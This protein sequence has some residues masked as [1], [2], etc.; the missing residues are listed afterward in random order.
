MKTSTDNLESSVVE[1]DL[2]KLGEYLHRDPRIVGATVFGSARDGRVRPGSDLDLAVLFD[3]PLPAEDF[4]DFY[5]ALCDQVPGVEKVDLI[6]LNQAD[7]ILAFEAIS[8]TFLCTND[9][10]KMAGYFSLVCREYEDVMGNLEH[11]RRMA[12]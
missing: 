12:A 1:V 8:G 2:D 4:L 5:S 11:Q 7:P 9:K 3:A 6:C 10:E